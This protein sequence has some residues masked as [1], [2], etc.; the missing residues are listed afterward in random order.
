MN[1]YSNE[2]LLN[3]SKQLHSRLQYNKQ[4]K[5][6]KVTVKTIKTWHRLKMLLMN[7]GAGLWGVERGYLFFTLK[8][9]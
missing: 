1:T 2:A 5:L 9:I 8:T 4:G 3:A 6:V 7:R